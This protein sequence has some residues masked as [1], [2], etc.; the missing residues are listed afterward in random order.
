M[1]RLLFIAPLAPDSL[2]G[3]DFFFRFPGLGLL[4]V[5]ALTPPDWEVVIID[6]KV[7]RLDLA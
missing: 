2:M 3:G 1:K 4:K 6:E 7:E 5:A